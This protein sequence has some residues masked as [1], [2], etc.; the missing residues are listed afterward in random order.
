M[1]QRSNQPVFIV[2]SPR[3]GTT[4]LYHILLSA[5]RFAIYRS[6]T[7]L[8]TTFGPAYGDFASRRDRA[9]FLER[10]LVSEYFLRSGLDAEQFYE[11]ALELGT[12]PG[13]MLRVFMDEIRA[14]QHAARWAEC[15]P[16]NAIHL[17]R[18]R[19][20]FPGALVIHIVRD[21]RDVAL[22]LAKQG[23]IK[24]FPWDKGRPERAAAAYWRWI[25]R[26]ADSAIAG[27]EGDALVLKYEDL[28]LDFE[29]SLRRLS[30]FIDQPL[31]RNRI[32]ASS[33]GS[34]AV[35]NSSFAESGQGFV[36]R[37]RSQCA[38]DLL[39]EIEAMIGP[40]L[41]AHRYPTHSERSGPINAWRAGLYA[42]RFA[43][44]A[45]LKSLSTFPGRLG[46]GGFSRLAAPGAPSSDPTL[47]PGT[48]VTLIREMV[49]G[50]G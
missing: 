13:A 37:W 16:D 43:T 50:H 26:R 24:P 17:A 44:A 1:Q 25:V 35:P 48:H 18:I 15:T 38:P 31:D 7:Q 41:A 42:A 4:W 29:Q 9:R 28:V 32:A 46:D 23:F 40:E 10:W 47:R 12:S 5:G 39:T 14:Y 36:G 22:S 6:E 30:E 49:A 33:I 2:G 3:S 27:F 11:K 34:V 21:G 20:D 45:R 8:Y 19:R